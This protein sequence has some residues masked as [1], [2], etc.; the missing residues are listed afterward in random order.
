MNSLWQYLTIMAITGS[1]PIFAAE[2]AGKVLDPDGMVVYNCNIE[3]QGT[4]LGTLSGSDG[5]FSISNLQAGSYVITASHL[6]YKPVILTV[7]FDEHQK[8][9]ITLQF[10]EEK[11]DILDEITVTATKDIARPERTP[12]SV[13]HIS[14]EEITRRFQYNAGEMLDFVPGIRVIRSGATVGAD[15]GISIRSLNGGPASN[16]TLVLEDGR[17]INN[18]WD[19]GLNFNMLP[20]EAIE[21]IEVV[22]GPASALYGSQ[23]TAG[24]INVISRSAPAG[25]H[26]WFSAATEWDAAQEIT[27]A[28]AEGYGR[29]E[30]NATNLQ[31]NGSYKRDRQSHMVTLGQRTSQQSY[32]TTTKQN[33]WQNYDFKYK[34]NYNLSNNLQLDVHT[35]LHSNNWRNEAERVPQ[36]EAYHFYSGDVQ[37]NYL[38]AIGIFNLRSYLNTIDLSVNSLQSDV[39]TG[40]NTYRLGLIGDYTRPLFTN[41]ASLKLGFDLYHDQAT[42]TYQQAVIDLTYQGTTTINI[43]DSKTGEVTPREV[44]F[45]DGNYGADKQMCDLTNTALF[46]QYTQ[47]IKERLT[48]VLGGR[49]DMHSAFGTIF[50][51]KA[52]ITYEIMRYKSA[53]TGFKVNY[54]TGFRAPA[55]ADLYSKSLNDYGNPGIKP[56]KT[57]NFDIGLFQRVTDFGYLELSYFKMD[58]KNLMINDKLGSTGWGQYAAIANTNGTIDTLA[59]NY[60]KNLGDY[61]PSGFEVGLKVKPHPQ[62]TL[63]GAYAYLDPQNFTFQT[64]RHRYNLTIFFM[65]PLGKHLLQAEI[66]YNYTGNGYFFDYKTMPYDAF[67]LTDATFGLS[68]WQHYKVSVIAKNLG[69]TRYKLWHYAWQPGRTLAVRFEVNY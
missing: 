44:D 12:Q 58:V 7:D 39:E 22:K 48:V 52:G 55:L 56:E 15:Y 4:T 21:H 65:Q 69:D 40:T 16:K 17:P 31:F 29:P 51:P 37:V 10:K 36:E 41:T 59:F 66:R 26:G 23:A 53:T 33:Q 60:R 61:T 63:Q 30:I 5:S 9:D 2:L 20:T 46:V 25:F 42:V 67:A 50:N 45:Y 11:I 14:S 62:L 68:L 3:I 32:F 18:G 47:D 8:T 19:G 35:G 54:G 28:E 27:D 38:S 64:S 43:T 49:L 6:A 1:L 34:L 24:V 13:A 57:K